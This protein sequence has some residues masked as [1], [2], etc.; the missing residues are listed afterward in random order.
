MAGVGQRL[1][2]DGLTGLVDELLLVARVRRL[3]VV[4]DQFEELL[5]QAT[6]AAR[7]R[8]TMLDIS[9]CGV[10]YDQLS[11]RHDAILG[12]QNG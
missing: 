6:P 12:G 10:S 4:V 2:G 9:L 8:F 3:L 5:T 11:S 1:D 7:D